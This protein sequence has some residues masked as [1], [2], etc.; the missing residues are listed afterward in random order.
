[1]RINSC[2]ADYQAEFGKLGPFRKKSQLPYH[3]TALVRIE[4]VFVVIDLLL[5]YY[6]FGRR[7]CKF[8][9]K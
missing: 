8:M 2:W 9:K 4:T 3:Y 1:M 7:R 5:G 6:S